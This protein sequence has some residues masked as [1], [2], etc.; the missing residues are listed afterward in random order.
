MSAHVCFFF[1]CVIKP[2][3][4][5]FFVREHGYISSALVHDFLSIIPILLCQKHRKEYWE[6]MQRSLSVD[7]YDGSKFFLLV[8]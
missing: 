5:S 7:F 1:D 3:K 6:G 2:S 4:K 8:E